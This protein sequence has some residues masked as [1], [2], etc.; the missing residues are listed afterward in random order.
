MSRA[1]LTRDPI[2]AGSVARAVA[3]P[4]NGATVVFIGTVRD[5]NDGRP[6]AAI[7]YRAYEAM[8][9][10]EL[11]R[12]AD[13]AEARFPG[14]AVAVVHRLGELALEEA[15]IVI[16]AA[17]PHRAEAFDAARHVIEETKR[18]VPIW[19]REHYRDGT[20]E[21]VDPTASAGI[22]SRP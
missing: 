11:A 6:V 12:I 22:G 13:E 8:A 20:R 21:W 18:R 3:G 10:D 16:A 4:A 2:D 19:K 7:D 15:S 9:A 17:H 5:H 1:W 14:T